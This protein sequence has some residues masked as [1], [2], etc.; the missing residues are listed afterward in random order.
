MRGIVPDEILDRKDKIGFQTP[1]KLWLTKMS[2]QVR[3]WLRDDVGLDFLNQSA[4]LKEFDDI[5]D[6]RKAFTWQAWR[7]I[8]FI[9]WYQLS[10]L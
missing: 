8:N 10:F 4:I 1:E 3:E 5:I 6:G 2:V 9:R 7:W